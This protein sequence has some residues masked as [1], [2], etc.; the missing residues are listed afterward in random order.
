MTTLENRLAAPY[1]VNHISTQNLL[2][3]LSIRYLSK[4]NGDISTQKD[5]GK[6]VQRLF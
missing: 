1:E 6:N 4:I 5:W 3:P 2:I